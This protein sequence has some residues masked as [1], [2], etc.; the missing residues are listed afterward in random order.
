MARPGGD[1]PWKHRSRLPGLLSRRNTASHRCRD[2]P[3]G[4]R[5]LSGPDAGRSPSVRSRPSEPGR[6]CMSLCAHLLHKG[7]EKTRRTAETRAAVKSPNE[8]TPY[9]GMIR[10][11][12]K[13]RDL[14]PLSAFRLPCF[15]D[16]AY[17]R[18][19]ILSRGLS[20]REK[21]RMIE[22]QQK[23]SP[24]ARAERGL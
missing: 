17:H 2:P 21:R 16:S 13:G 14:S 6:R 24:L 15:S 9:G 8:Q 12:C 4:T 23:G 20:S 5:V 11:R 3:G 18:G 1:P 22:K 7:F 19:K 10:V